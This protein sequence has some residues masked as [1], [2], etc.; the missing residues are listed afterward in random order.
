MGPPTYARTTNSNELL[1]DQ[2]RSTTSPYLCLSG[3]PNFFVTRMLTRDLFAVANLV[4]FPS[5][6][7]RIKMFINRFGVYSYAQDYRA[8]LIQYKTVARQSYEVNKTS[9]GGRIAV[10]TRAL[11]P[12]FIIQC[13][14]TTFPQQHDRVIFDTFC[15]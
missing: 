13:S 5:V 14:P 8:T 1:H 9:R 12:I 6:Y 15:V 10:V 2:R 4:I 3:G 11:L 7:W